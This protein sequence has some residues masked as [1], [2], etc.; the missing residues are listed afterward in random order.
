[1]PPR[2]MP[3]LIGLWIGLAESWRGP[4]KQYKAAEINAA[5][6]QVEDPGER[7]GRAPSRRYSPGRVCH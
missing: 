3:P 7:P 5:L 6:H 2:R 4:F 1:M